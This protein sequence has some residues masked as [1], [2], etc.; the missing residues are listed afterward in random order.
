[1][2]VVRRPDVEPNRPRAVGV[3]ED[4]DYLA[5]PDVMHATRL[6]EQ[7]GERTR[8]HLTPAQRSLEFG[9]THL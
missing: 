8:R 6:T 5:H 1:M 4:G 2:R 3:Y 9:L 7:V